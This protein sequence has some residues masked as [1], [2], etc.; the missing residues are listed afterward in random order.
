[1][2]WFLSR[3]QARSEDR[4][5]EDSILSESAPTR[6]APSPEP[7]LIMLATDADG[8]SC[9]RLHCFTD[10]E[11]AAR[12]VRFWYPY[13]LDNSVGGFWLLR[14]EPLAV[15]RAEWGVVVLIIVRGARS[16]LVYAFT[17][18]DMEST[19]EFLREEFAYGLDPAA[20]IVCWAVPAEI[21]TDPRGEAVI[22]PTSLPAGVT[23]G[24][25]AISAL[26][27]RELAM[28]PAFWKSERSV[29]RPFS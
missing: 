25:P 28:A 23:A 20:V 17:R 4:L 29:G 26:D 3:H 2:S 13:R 11:S 15:D 19:R 12:F 1:M 8:P 18:R 6:R 27:Q 7:A 16:G 24:N 9:R 5:I 21:E 22:F 10:A 14:A